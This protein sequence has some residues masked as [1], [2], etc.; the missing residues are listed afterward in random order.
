MLRYVG[1]IHSCERYRNIKHRIALDS[2]RAN[3]HILRMQVACERARIPAIRREQREQAR[4]RARE[5]GR[6]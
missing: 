5:W 4:P 6:A 3:T 1:W 2:L